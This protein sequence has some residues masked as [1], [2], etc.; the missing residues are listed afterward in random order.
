MT[1]SREELINAL[2]AEW[3]Y[4]CHDDFDPETDLTPDEYREH[5]E[6]MEYRELVEETSTDQYF[7]LE[8]YMDRYL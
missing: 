7:T 8:E 6:K 2:C 1:Y 4:L 5:L 3:E